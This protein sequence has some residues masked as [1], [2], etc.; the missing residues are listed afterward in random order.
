ME[1]KEFLQQRYDEIQKAITMLQM[2]ADSI[3]LQLTELKCSRTGSELLNCGFLLPSELEENKDRGLI[4]WIDNT[5]RK[6]LT[7]DEIMQTVRSTMRY[8]QNNEVRNKY[9][10]LTNSLKK[11]I[12]KRG[13]TNG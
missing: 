5:A 9:A 2:T 11:A 4:S 8:A 7:D 13:V 1:D 12:E 3:R 6:Y 10:L